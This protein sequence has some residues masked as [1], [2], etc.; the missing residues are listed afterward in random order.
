[1]YDVPEGA[2][3]EELVERTVY[4]AKTRDPPLSSR[5]AESCILTPHQTTIA[6]TDCTTNTTV[7]VTQHLPQ[8]TLKSFPK[9]TMGKPIRHHTR[10]ITN[11]NNTTLHHQ[12]YR[13]LEILHLRSWD[14]HHPYLKYLHI[15]NNNKDPPLSLVIL[16]QQVN[17]RL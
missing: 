7:V 4:N 15:Y 8:I 9:S 6:N 14:H 13:H 17:V 5:L 11:N 16:M 1:M 3:D 10:V 12:I 2:H